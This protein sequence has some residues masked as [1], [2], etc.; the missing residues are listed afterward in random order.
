M[1]HTASTKLASI[2]KTLAA[3]TEAFT[4]NPSACNWRCL[5]ATMLRYQEAHQAVKK[6][7][8]KA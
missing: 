8:S 4:A 3:D 1:T 2:K 5:E 6:D 7:Q